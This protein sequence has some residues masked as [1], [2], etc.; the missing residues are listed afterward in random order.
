MPARMRYLAWRVSGA[1]RFFRCSLRLRGGPLLVMRP[2]PSSDYDTA[3]EIFVKRIYDL[4]P[5]RPKNVR[6]IVDLGG[7]VGYS[8]LYWC[9]LYPEAEVLTYEPHP[10]HCGILERHMLR[11]RYSERVKLVRAAAGVR[12]GPCQLSDA[13]DA[14]AV[15][16]SGDPASLRPL[17]QVDSADVFEGIGPDRIDILKMDIEG[18]EYEIMSDPRFDEVMARTRCIL[19][20]WHKRGPRHFGLDWCLGR[21]RTLGFEVEAGPSYCQEYGMV[22]GINIACGSS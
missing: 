18:A 3:Y 2:K 17:M 14:S 13:S 6:R 9:W 20:E 1:N 11:N 21:L 4:G 5:D 8:C 10:V 15:V 16:H 22:R 12:N 7:N 19:L